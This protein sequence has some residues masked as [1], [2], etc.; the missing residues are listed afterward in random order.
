M[1]AVARA[2]SKRAPAHGQSRQTSVAT[3]VHTVATK[4]TNPHHPLKTKN[5]LYIAIRIFDLNFPR[6][7]VVPFKFFK[8]QSVY[9]IVGCGKEGRSFC[10]I[11][12]SI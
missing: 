12:N 2:D 11:D 3:E 7:I 4:C 5:I 1:A 6:Y 10:L 8:S 9:Q